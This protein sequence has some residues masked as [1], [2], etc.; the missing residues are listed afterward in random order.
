MEISD[1]RENQAVSMNQIAL[2]NQADT[3]KSGSTH[4]L[5]NTK[6]EPRAFDKPWILLCFSG[7][8]FFTA[9]FDAEKGI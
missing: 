1:D 8:A 7:Y 9:P 5:D 2:I 6:E 4:K 3:H